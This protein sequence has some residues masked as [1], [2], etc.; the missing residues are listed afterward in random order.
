MSKSVCK[1]ENYQQLYR[2]HGEAVRNFLYYKIGDIGRAEDVCHEAFI[3]LWENCKKVSLEKAKSFVFTV[4]N[5]LFLNQVRHKKVALEFEKYFTGY[6]TPQNPEEVMREND[7]KT[8]LENAISSLPDKQRESFL[9]NRI[10]KMTYREIAELEGV[11]EKAIEKRISKA[12]IFLKEEV[13]E[14]NKYKI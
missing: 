5:N 8:L 13:Q 7:F 11:S 3:K 10:D 2:A 14:L 9:L 6:S 1:E 12:L 4:A